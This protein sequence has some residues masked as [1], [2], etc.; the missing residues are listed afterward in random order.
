MKKIENN[1]EEV[2]KI[3]NKYQKLRNSI[4]LVVLVLLIIFVLRFL[5]TAK[6]M[7]E[8]LKNNSSIDFDGNFKITTTGVSASE[9]YYKDGKM[10]IKH[11]DNAGILFYDGV[12]YTVDHSRKQYTKL[13]NFMLN[14]TN[15]TLLNSI[16]IEDESINSFSKMMIMAWQNR[17]K[18]GSEDLNEKEYLTLEFKSFSQ[19]YWINKETN[20]VERESNDGQITEIKFEQ[21]VVNDEDIKLPWEL[22]YTEII[23]QNN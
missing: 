19:K 18:V 14:T 9:R 23:N 2:V 20:L 6:T 22:G 11:N 17:A 4:L 3:K 10:Y 13:E 21:N 8:I 5:Y 16:F 12:V 15:V 7:Q 1:N